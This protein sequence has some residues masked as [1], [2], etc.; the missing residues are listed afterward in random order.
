MLI[1]S[2]FS[3]LLDAN[4]LYPAPLRDY[5]LRLA[6]T[7]I[8]KPHWTATIQEEWISNLLENRKDL[9]RESLERTKMAMDIAFPD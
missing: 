6:S 9:T 2:R 1:S 7:G 5:L 4:V 3:A 8:Y